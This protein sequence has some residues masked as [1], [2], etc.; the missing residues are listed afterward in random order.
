MD[1]GEVYFNEDTLDEIKFIE[2]PER[3]AK[4]HNNHKSMFN[5]AQSH[6]LEVEGG[7]IYPH[8]KKG[9]SEELP[10]DFLEPE[11]KEVGNYFLEFRK[12]LNST[13]VDPLTDS[14]AAV[15]IM[16]MF[17]EKVLIKQLPS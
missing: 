7:T 8:S 17:R 6:I 5:D 16:L 4:I 11:H 2:D 10:S 14:Q 15:R 3:C 9:L 12:I 1:R 13:L